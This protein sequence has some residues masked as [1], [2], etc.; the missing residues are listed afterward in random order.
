[1]NVKGLGLK[2]ESVFV[3]VDLYKDVKIFFFTT[4][5]K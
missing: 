4:Y 5:M 1:M 3:S 2:M